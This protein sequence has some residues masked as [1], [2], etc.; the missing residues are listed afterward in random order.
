MAYLVSY[1]QTVDLD[2]QRLVLTMLRTKLPLGGA[3][4]HGT[5]QFVGF[6]PLTLPFFIYPQSDSNLQPYRHTKCHILRDTGGLG[7]R[8]GPEKN[9][10]GARI[11]DSDLQGIGIQGL[12]QAFLRHNP[13]CNSAAP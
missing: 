2:N 6:Q 9:G 10:D 4:K 1:S 13:S 11:L 7:V 12:S 5:K 8:E 3:S